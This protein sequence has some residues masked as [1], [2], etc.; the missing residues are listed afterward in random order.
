MTKPRRAIRQESAWL[1]AASGLLTL[2]WAVASARMLLWPVHALSGWL[3]LLLLPVNV[4][5][6]CCEIFLH[7]RW[8]MA[9]LQFPGWAT[10]R[11]TAPRWDSPVRLIGS[12]LCLG[13]LA[14]LV[15]EARG[16]ELPFSWDAAICL[17]MLSV[18]LASSLTFYNYRRS[19]LSLP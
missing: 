14:L 3:L 13:P 10:S 16:A 7:R 1:L 2:F 15:S 12:L 17:L 19:I 11:L 5:L 9:G 18:S 4:S 6:L 8:F